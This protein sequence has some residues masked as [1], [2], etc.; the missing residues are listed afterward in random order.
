MAAV[1]E[2]QSAALDQIGA[3]TAVREKIFGGNFDRLFPSPS[4]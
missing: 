3:T 2:E 1:Y 4:L